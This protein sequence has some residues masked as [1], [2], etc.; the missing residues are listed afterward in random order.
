MS[1]RPW[2][3]LLLA[4]LLLTLCA[5]SSKDSVE[6]E[7]YEA[8]GLRDPVETP[9]PDASVP[10]DDEAPAL[11]AEEPSADAP[12]PE[13][14]ADPASDA[15]TSASDIPVEEPEEPVPEFSSGSDVYATDGLGEGELNDVMHTYF[16]D[17]TVTS[18]SLNDA[19][20]P[21]VADDGST[22]L[23]LNVTVENTDDASIEMY[24]TDFQVIWDDP[25]PDAF[26]YPI[27]LD[28]DTGEV[29]PAQAVD[30]MPGQYA[31]G[32]GEAR[33]G[34]LIYQVPDGYDYFAVG[35]QEIFTDG[36]EQFT[37]DAFL[38]YFTPAQTV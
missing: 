25:D 16:F 28:L 14:A 23:V 6:N 33:T 35:H 1:R 27:T 7:V 2:I 12:V 29:V 36:T 22:L 9:A 10:E 24:A 3:A 18:A 37:G 32:I 38:V 4:L 8:L 5:C 20:G 15:D 30:E 26:A 31:L 13:T 19:Y 11:P 34:L 17:F 21:Y